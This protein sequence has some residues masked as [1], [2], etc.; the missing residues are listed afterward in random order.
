MA[1]IVN[2]SPST[3]TP[4]PLSTTPWPGRLRCAWRTVFQD[5]AVAR[6]CPASPLSER[7]IRT[8]RRRFAGRLPGFPSAEAD[9]Q[10]DRPAALPLPR[11]GGL[12]RHTSEVTVLRPYSANPQGT[13]VCPPGTQVA[14]AA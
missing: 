13:R 1:T 10:Q 2:A 9:L 3:A 6:V 12:G 7:R 8:G 5:R 4:K 14:G 11:P